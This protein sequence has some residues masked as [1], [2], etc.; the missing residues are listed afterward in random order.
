MKL[1]KRPNG[2]YAVDYIDG[3]GKRKRVSTDTR[4]L[5][6]ARARM[7]DIVRGAEPAKERAEAKQVRRQS[8]SVSPESSGGMTVEQMLYSCLRNGEVWGD[9][10]KVRAQASIKSNVKVVSGYIGSVPVHSLT[11][12]R[13]EEFVEHMKTEGYAPGTI[14]RKLTM[15]RAALRTLTVP[16]RNGEPPVLAAMPPFP[17]ITVKNFKDR[18]IHHDEEVRMFETAEKLRQW[19]PTQD[20]WTF[21]RFLRV[22]LDAGSRL[23]ETLHLGPASVRNITKNGRTEPFLFFPGTVTKSGKSRMIPCSAAIAKLI[24]E[25]NSR[26]IN[27]RWFSFS[28]GL[29]QYRWR[30]LREEMRPPFTDVTIHTF[31]H[32]CLTRLV[33]GGMDIVRLSKWAGHANIKI[34]VERYGHLEAADLMEGIDIIEAN[35]GWNNRQTIDEI[36]TNGTISQTDATP[37]QTVPPRHGQARVTH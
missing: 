5:G 24:P 7:L 6:I 33:Q 26:A 19:S 22:L 30:Q 17:T 28:Q 16:G 13:L 27:G 34:T 18:V 14:N 36:P 35:A 8:V 10:A 1:K 37:A 25:L 11:L 2:I 31:R 20:W 4:D 15:L 21:I 23:T 3:D 29:A 12:G 32:T 9:P